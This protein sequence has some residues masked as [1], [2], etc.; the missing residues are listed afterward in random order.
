M[1]EADLDDFTIPVLGKEVRVTG[2]LREE[3]H[4]LIEHAGFEVLESSSFTYAPASTDVPPEEQLFLHCSR[5]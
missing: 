4:E 2:Y 3:L 5:S 1:V